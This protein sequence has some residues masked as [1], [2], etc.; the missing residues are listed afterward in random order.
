MV[1]IRFFL[2]QLR[3]SPH[4]SIVKILYYTILYYT[5]IYYTIL[6]YTICIVKTLIGT[7]KTW[8][9][10]WM[11]EKCYFDIDINFQEYTSFIS[12]ELCYWL[13][14]HI[15]NFTHTTGMTLLKVIQA[16]CQLFRLFLC[17][18]KK[19]K[20]LQREALTFCFM[21]IQFVP[22]QSWR[23]LSISR[24]D[25]HAAKIF[26]GRGEG[27]GMRL[28]MVSC[29]KSGRISNNRWWC[30]LVNCTSFC[31]EDQRFSFWNC[32]K[33]HYS[34]ALLTSFFR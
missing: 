15:Y 29:A 9:W 18:T 11:A 22:L 20:K 14:S 13:P 16:K 32:Q 5:I 1:I 27:G 26:G 33:L 21:L 6:Y 34:G 8:W 2:N 25:Y 23:V 24:R 28:P 12:Y 31:F 4:K 3:F 7:D 19:I 30:L 10:P 17:I